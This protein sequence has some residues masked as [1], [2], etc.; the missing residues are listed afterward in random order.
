M[1]VDGCRWDEHLGR[2]GVGGDEDEIVSR[3]G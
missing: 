1:G 2:W 3:D